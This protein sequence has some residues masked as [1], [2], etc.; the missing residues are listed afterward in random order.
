[1]TKKNKIEIYSDDSIENPPVLCESFKHA[2]YLLIER[3]QQ[4]DTLL[5]TLYHYF[6]TQKNTANTLC[7]T[8]QDAAKSLNERLVKPSVINAMSVP[9]EP[10][11]KS[12]MKRAKAKMDAFTENLVLMGHK[13][14]FDYAEHGG[15]LK[16]M[17][18]L[19][20]HAEQMAL[21]EEKRREYLLNN[22]ITNLTI[23]KDT[24]IKDRRQCLQDWSDRL[25]ETMDIQ[26][27]AVTAYQHL[28]VATEKFKINRENTPL[29]EHDP[30]LRWQHYRSL[31][32]TFINK[33]N[34]LQVSAVIHQEECKKK[35]N[36]IV[37][38]LQNIIFEYTTTTTSHNLKIKALFSKHAI[39]FDADGEWQHFLSN[40]MSVVANTPL[41]LIRPRNLRFL[42]DDHKRTK[43][44][45]EAMLFLEPVFPWSFR[46]KRT[47]RQYVVTHGGY[48]I[49][50]P[51]D[52]AKLPIPIR[53]FRLLD[54]VVLEDLPRLNERLS[55]TV[56]G[57]NCCR[58]YKSNLMDRRTFWRFTG[59]NKEVEN[60]L[61]AIRLNMPTFGYYPTTFY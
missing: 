50:V 12:S 57:I 11:Q 37:H 21:L 10:R 22:T 3:F 34:I 29:P 46:S 55:F 48:L 51:T 14:K 32:D 1:M 40:N 24:T 27:K 54:C 17:N 28:V 33:M 18:R 25:N 43:P 6:E 42:N 7:N 59:A 13:F 4:W 16:N 8:Y 53:A 30:L 15:V 26:Q 56:S 19:R 5:T 61:K 35:E 20:D 45:A 38:T 31:R 41:E 60:L 2:I 23:L 39:P 44:L 58:D 52:E 36:E 47:L 9:Q 49:K